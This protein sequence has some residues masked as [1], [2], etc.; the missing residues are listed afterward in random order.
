[1][2]IRCPQ[3]SRLLDAIH[4]NV[5]TDVAVC[6]S[7]NEA[8]AISSVVT[9][10]DEVDPDFDLYKSPRGTSFQETG[11]GWTLTATTRSPIAFFLVPFM[12]IWSGFSLGGI[13]G[14]QIIKGQFDLMTSLFGIPFLFGTILFGSIAVM[15]V[16]G[17]VRVSV[18]Q[19]D[20]NI[21]VGVGSIGWK[22]RFD[23]SSIVAVKEVFASRGGNGSSG[24]TIHLVGPAPLQFGSML[25]DSRRSYV[26][27]A[28]R[29]LL[30]DRKSSRMA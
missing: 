6:P 29:H 20:G 17:C 12:C 2:K 10:A 7:C 15:S 23:W 1:M 19:D 14:T 11:F 16:F 13:Y 27:N 9:G 26:I 24:Y 22:R 3:C 25:S 5:A 21:F 28:L 8:F 4:L 30:A 18:D